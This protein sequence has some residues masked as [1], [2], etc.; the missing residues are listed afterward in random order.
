MSTAGYGP[1]TAVVSS[2][3]LPGIGHGKKNCIRVKTRKKPG[4]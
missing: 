4:K 2:R 3:I 1:D